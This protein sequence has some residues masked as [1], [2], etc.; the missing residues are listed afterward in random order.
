M[1]GWAAATLATHALFVALQTIASAACVPI[2]QVT[3]RADIERRVAGSTV[4]WPLQADTAHTTP[5]RAL[6]PFCE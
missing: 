4:N 5:Q 3:E 1:S 2:E 6:P